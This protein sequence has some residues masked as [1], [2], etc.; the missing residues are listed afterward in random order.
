MSEIIEGTEDLDNGPYIIP[1]STDNGNEQNVLINE[2]LR[3]LATHQHTNQDSLAAGLP[4]ST[5][6]TYTGLV[7]GTVKLA[8]GLYNVSLDTS[9]S[10]QLKAIDFST[11]SVV[12]QYKLTT[13]SGDVEN[14]M[15]FYPTFVVN[16]GGLG[17]TVY[18]NRN[19]V[20]IRIIA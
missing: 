10:G 17:A 19:D 12:F 5:I 11:K 14:W 7:F 3:R 18:L 1:T 16:A 6:R 2:A 8:D 9:A 15:Q 13:D 4:P 20:D